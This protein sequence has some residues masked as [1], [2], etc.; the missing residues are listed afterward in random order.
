MFINNRHINNI[1]A[2]VLDGLV[3]EKLKTILDVF[4]KK[5]KELFHI[6]K[7]SDVSKVP[8]ASSFRLI[9]KLV[10]LGFLDIIRINKFKLYRL[11]NN[12]KTKILIGLWKK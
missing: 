11:A 8:L 1:M 9:K 4:I 5:P 6:Q 2:G 3:D 7:V 12:K 10:K